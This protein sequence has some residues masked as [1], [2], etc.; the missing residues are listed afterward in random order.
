MIGM[1]AATLGLS[2]R[3]GGPSLVSTG[4]MLLIGL[5]AVRV[6]TMAVWFALNGDRDFALI[7]AGVLAIIVGSTLLGIGAG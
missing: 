5:P 7:A 2:L 3:W 6:A 1:L 4:I